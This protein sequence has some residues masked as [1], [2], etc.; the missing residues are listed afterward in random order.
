MS[1]ILYL[2]F[3]IINNVFISCLIILRF[4]NYLKV[5]RL[6]LYGEGKRLFN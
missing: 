4:E 5:I 1:F 6:H 3:N 2:S